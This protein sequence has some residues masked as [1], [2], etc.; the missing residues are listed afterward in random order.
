MLL[1]LLMQTDNAQNPTF[2]LATSVVVV[3]LDL[4]T[5]AAHE[6]HTNIASQATMLL[7]FHR[8]NSTSPPIPSMQKCLLLYPVDGRAI[9]GLEELCWAPSLLGD[10]GVHLCIP[11][12]VQHQF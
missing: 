6:Q 8:S 1:L 9:A 7:L 11:D 3:H 2:R 5:L 4:R 10:K 12:H